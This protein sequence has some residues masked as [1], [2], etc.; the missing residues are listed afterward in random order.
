[1][2]IDIPTVLVELRRQVVESESGLDPE[3]L[4]MRAA[5]KAFGSRKAYERAQ[6]LAKLGRHVRWLPGWSATRDVPAVPQE[7]FRDWWRSR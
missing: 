1:V 2:K 7:T 5:A 3:H 6:R 4:A